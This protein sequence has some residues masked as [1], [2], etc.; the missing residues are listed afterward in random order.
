MTNLNLKRGL[1]IALEGHAELVCKDVAAPATIHVVPDQFAGVTPKVVVRA[2]DVVKVGTP[3]FYDKQQPE[4]QFVSPVAGTISEVVRGDRRKVLSIDITVAAQSECEKFDMKGDLKALLLKSGLWTLL[5]QRPYDCIAMPSK[6]PKAI[7]ISTFCSAPLA[8]AYEWVIGQELD[9]LQLAIS[10]LTKIAPVYVGIRPDSTFF[11]NLKD[12]TLYTV[13]GKHPAG[14]VGVQINHIAPMGK[15]DTVYTLNIQDALVIGR[16]LAS[17][18]LDFT[19]KV[20]VTG[21]KADHPQYYNVVPGTELGEFITPAPATTI[22]A[23]NALSGLSVD[24]KTPVWQGD[25]Q[26][27]LLEDGTNTHEFMG[28]IAPAFLRAGKMDTRL[29]G[30]HRALIVSGEYD[31]VFPMD[32]YPEQLLRAMMVGNLDNMIA[33]GANEVAPEDFALCEYVCTS[34]IPVQRIVREALD[35]LRKEIE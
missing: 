23:G 19:R 24:L 20:A 12:C 31:K 11:S 15:V 4:I 21:P 17:G 33:L 5:R 30:G 32:I 26:Y 9:K 16:F 2:G 22:V 13:A 34:K 27:T 7:F 14:N 18:T 25:N 1:D 28:W 3:L 6:T 29:K 8:P 10:S 35:N